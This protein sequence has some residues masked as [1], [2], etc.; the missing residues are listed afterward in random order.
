MHLHFFT[1]TSAC[2]PSFFF[3]ILGSLIERPVQAGLAEGLQRTL[4]GSGSDLSPLTSSE[5]A[6]KA[7]VF[8][9]PEIPDDTYFFLEA[10]TASIQRYIKPLPIPIRQRGRKVFARIGTASDID[11]YAP[12]SSLAS[13]VV[14]KSKIPEVQSLA[15][16]VLSCGP[17]VTS[18]TSTA[19]RLLNS[20]NGFATQL[21]QKSLIVLNHASLTEGERTWIHGLISSLEFHFKI[22]KGLLR[23]KSLKV[24]PLSR[25]QL[26]HLRLTLIQV[27]NSAEWFW[28][29][30]QSSPE[31][32]MLELKEILERVELIAEMK[33]EITQQK[34]RKLSTNIV[35]LYNILLASSSINLSQMPKAFTDQALEA[36]RIILFGPNHDWKQKLTLSVWDHL[37]KSSKALKVEF[38]RLLFKSVEMRTVIQKRNAQS[39]IQH[40]RLQSELL[41]EDT[42]MF[43]ILVHG[44]KWDPPSLSE[45]KLYNN[46]IEMAVQKIKS[47]LTSIEKKVLIYQILSISSSYRTEVKISLSNAYQSDSE[48]RQDVIMI[49]THLHPDIVQ[50]FNMDPLSWEYEKLKSLGKLWKI[51]IYRAL[52][53]D[54]WKGVS[55]LKPLRALLSDSGTAKVNE[56]LFRTATD[57]LSNGFIRS[58]QGLRPVDNMIPRRYDREHIEALAILSMS[59]KTYSEKLTQLMLERSQIRYR[60]KQEQR[61]K[62]KLVTQ[63]V[64]KQMQFVP[65]TDVIELEE[66]KKEIQAV[67]N[68][69]RDVLQA[70]YSLI[71]K[72]CD[73][74]FISGIISVIFFLPANID[75]GFTYSCYSSYL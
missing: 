58:D 46:F 75:E 64:K 68:F 22:D 69:Q 66:D 42:T 57:Y 16:V 48:F 24:E 28:R 26:E 47:T 45:L 70:F 37:T 9:R 32:V 15:Q 20:G 74:L 12:F 39:L 73:S 21:V 55:E 34:T 23:P 25:G 67:E 31:P 40:S 14:E 30:S 51:E 61:K 60:I 1:T 44:F 52:L 71:N 72:V 49:W 6:L 10:G 59:D 11:H 62:D 43:H 53:V 5:L 2:Y 17:D 7:K 13:S 4:A 36:I 54:S 63:T 35:K 29:G 65:D 18:L 33:R 27:K 8:E 50:Q 38:E 19:A 56:E 41:D 3:L